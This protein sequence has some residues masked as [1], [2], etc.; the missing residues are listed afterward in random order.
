M[1]PDNTDWRI[2]LIRTKLFLSFPNL[3]RDRRII[4]KGHLVVCRDCLRKERE[5]KKRLRA[6]VKRRIRGLSEAK[7]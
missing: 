6:E 2:E 5:A 4:L 1:T 3:E 7:E